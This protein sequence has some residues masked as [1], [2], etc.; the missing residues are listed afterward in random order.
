MTRR[1]PSA[2]SAF[3]LIELL[4]VVAIIAILISILLPSLRAA[5]EQARQ[6]I[7]VTNLR[8]MGQAAFFYA[9]ANQGLIVR[10]ETEYMHFASSLLPGLG[11]TDRAIADL[12]RR[13]GGGGSAPPKFRAAMR[14]AALLQCPSFPQ[15]EQ[16]LDYVVNAYGDPYQR[17]GSENGNE[18]TGDGPISALHIRAAFTKMDDMSANILVDGGTLG[19]SRTA[20]PPNMLQPTN[21]IYIA[22]AHANMPL[23]SDSAWAQLTDLFVFSHLPFASQP[24]INNDRRHPGGVAALF[25]D[26]HADVVGF[27]KIDPGFGR[28]LE[29][30]MRLFTNFIPSNQ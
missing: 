23:P 29:D 21:R 26:G 3:T 24:R 11:Y 15:P 7:C 27:K 2:P 9:E 20:L 8:S 17:R 5:R 12:W 16:T 18:D 30:R 25:F 13:P 14:E 4:V 19:I 1:R 22:E 10:G 6:L 28:P